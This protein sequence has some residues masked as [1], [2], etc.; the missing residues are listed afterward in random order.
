VITVEDALALA[1]SRFAAPIQRDTPQLSEDEQVQLEYLDATVESGIYQ[2]YDGAVFDIKIPADF[3][4]AAVVATLKQRYEAGGWIVGVF[5]SA[6]SDDQIT[7]FQVV[8][9]APMAGRRAFAAGEVRA[10]TVRIIGDDNGWGLSRDR[11]ILAHA[12]E[13]MG[14]KVSVTDRFDKSLQNFVAVNVHLEIPVA[15]FFGLAKRNVIV[16]NPEWWSPGW[17]RFLRHPSVSV[18]AKTADADRFFR[19][20][21]AR[22]SPIGFRSIDKYDKN[23]A[24]ERTFLHVAGNAANKGTALLASLWQKEWPQLIVVGSARQ[25]RTTSFPP[26]VVTRGKISEDELRALQNR[27][28]FHIYPSLYEGFGH[29]QWEGISCGAVVIVLEHA[30]PFDAWPDIFSRIPVNADQ[31]VSPD[32]VAAAVTQAAAMTDEEISDRRFTARTA[33]EKQISE[34]QQ[35]MRS[36]IA[37]LD[38]SSRARVS[39]G[40]LSDI[41]PMNYV[42]RVNCVTGYGTAARHQIWTLRQHGLRLRIVDGGSVAD[43][44]PAHEDIFIQEARR[45]SPGIDRTYGTIIH[46]APNCVQKTHLQNPRPHI[47]VSVWETTKLP[48][49]WVSI[50]NSFDQVWCPTE[51]QRGVYAASGVDDQKL[52]VVPFAVDPSLYVIDG[53]TL[54]DVKR[55]ER[56][57]FGTVFQWTERKNPTALL[58]AYFRAFSAADLVTLVLKGYEG[59]DPKTSVETHVQE[60]IDSLQHPSPPDVRVISRPLTSLEMGAFYQ[61]IDCY[62][63]T[64][65]GEAFGFPIAEALCWGKPV[66]ATNWSAPA[67]YAAGCF[68]GV[69]YRL[70]PPHGMDWQPFYTDDQ[71]WADVDVADFAAAMRESHEKRLAFSSD[72]VRTQF[73]ALFQRAG[74]SAR[75][76]LDA[77]R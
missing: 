45:S 46:I 60:I 47:L 32:A 65:R 34:F 29:A 70:V 7:S 57:V 20:L 9:T 22:I 66:I 1:N 24:R 3:T 43:P 74:E 26:W 49:D 21:G 62:V 54:P 17:N 44:D 33:W 53:R 6:Q 28:L 64:H 25:L 59:D 63:S 75:A 73:E 76:A 14:W 37:A 16:P 19:E 40:I 18:W 61:S 55:A 38:D 58:D 27:C 30:P 8:F 48:K 11:G 15:S 56:T 10:R 50:I 71:L 12:F 41:P 31:S 13:E 42:G 68:R 36:A 4:T 51:W 52:R 67:E 72:R 69:G 39:L 35:S 77:L 2:S 5:P 23:I